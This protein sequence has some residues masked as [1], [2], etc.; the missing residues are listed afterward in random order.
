LDQRDNQRQEPQLH[1]AQTHEMDANTRCGDPATR[2]EDAGSLTG[3]LD[4]RGTLGVSGLLTGRVR[5]SIDCSPCSG[6][7]H[8]VS[9]RDFSGSG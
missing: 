9:W 5:L 8:S 7:R 4:A 3:T 1:F 6:R 2:N